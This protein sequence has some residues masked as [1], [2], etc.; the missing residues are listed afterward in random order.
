MR[1]ALYQPAQFIPVDTPG[2]DRE[3]AHWVIVTVPGAYHWRFWVHP[4][5][6]DA[7]IAHMSPHIYDSPEA[8]LDA[9]EEWTVLEEYR[10][11]K[12]RR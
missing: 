6:D 10:R 3:L 7:T 2:Q 9:G 11:K 8:A 5:R 4:E 1:S 12:A